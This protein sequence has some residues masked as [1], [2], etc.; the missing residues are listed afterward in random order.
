MRTWSRLKRTRY[1]LFLSDSEDGETEGLDDHPYSFTD[2]WSENDDKNEEL[3]F[4]QF[5]LRSA[6]PTYTELHNH[7]GE[8]VKDVM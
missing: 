3:N 2:D 1:I 8:V 7:R 5:S 4:T 6:I